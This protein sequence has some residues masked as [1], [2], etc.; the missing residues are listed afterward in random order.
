MWIVN[1]N[2]Y[3]WAVFDLK[4]DHAISKIRIYGWKS[5]EMPF[6]CF[7]QASNTLEYLFNNFNY[8]FN[9]NTFYF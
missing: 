3:L 2:K 6:E 7:F 1:G 4:A 9:L 5:K 8:N